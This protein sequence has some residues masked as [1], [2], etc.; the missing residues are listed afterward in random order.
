MY[1]LLLRSYLCVIYLQK[2]IER[3]PAAAK[4][5][6]ARRRGYAAEE[7]L[8]KESESHTRVALLALGFDVTLEGGGGGGLAPW[9]ATPIRKWLGMYVRCTVCSFAARRKTLRQRTYE[10]ERRCGSTRRSG[11]RGRQ[12]HGESAIINDPG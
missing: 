6:H 9:I 2:H 1:V 11:G 3:L 7:A 12:D 10:S 4:R 8:P 5:K